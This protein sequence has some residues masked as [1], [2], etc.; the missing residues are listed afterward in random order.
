[1]FRHRAGFQRDVESERLRNGE[2]N[3][4]EVVRLETVLLRRDL[5]VTNRKIW[6]AIHARGARRSGAVC[7]GFDISPDDIT[8]MNPGSRV[9]FPASL[10]RSGLR[11]GGGH[12]RRNQR[13]EY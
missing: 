6:N 12:T 4:V 5:V 13:S 1:L 8:A 9:V 3:V 10:D 11:P 2:L 7:V